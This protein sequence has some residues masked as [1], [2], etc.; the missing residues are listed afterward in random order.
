MN[1]PRIPAMSAAA[2]AVLFFMIGPR[3]SAASGTAGDTI[4]LSAPGG[5]SRAEVR[6]RTRA[7]TALGRDMFSDPSLSASGKLACASCHAPDHAL[8]PANALSVQFGGADMRQPGLRAVPSLKYVQI[9]PQFSEH[10]YDSEDDSDESVDNG[11]TG[12]LTWDGR[13]DR[14]ADQARIPLLSPFEMGNESAGNVVD[15]ALRAGYGER[16]R[17]IYGADILG[18]R[19]ALFDGILEAFEVYEQDEATFYPYSSKYDA[20][21]AGKATLSPA[22]AHG[23]ELFNDPGKGNCAECHISQR[24]NDGTPP[25]F[26][27]Y[28]LIALGVPRNLDIPANRDPAYFDLGLCGPLRTDFRGR[29]DYCG[30]FRTPSLRNVATRQTFF[31]NGAFHSLKK[32]VEFYARRDTN[33]EQWYP[34]R[35]DGTVDKFDDLP[36]AYQANIN[37][38]P[39]FDR[40]A[41][42]RPALDDKEID[43][44]VAF[45]QTLNDGYVAEQ[46]TARLP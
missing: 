14:G 35:A 25:Q 37:T 46:G 38:D 17:T 34:R 20:Y 31:H 21:L 8:G 24:G 3:L 18:D 30:L 44:I 15:R 42:D 4:V 45:L 13:A 9:V 5:L 41:G 33:P 28:G 40:H 29:T 12:G 7:L 19:K 6:R 27:D 23:L 43:D 39:P 32:A 11:P 36:A 1:I 10:F 26:T 16:L 22:E 2:V